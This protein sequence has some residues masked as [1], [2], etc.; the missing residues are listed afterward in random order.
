MAE[1]LTSRDLTGVWDAMDPEDAERF[2]Q[3]ILDPEVRRRWCTAVLVGG[4][5][6]LWQR[7]ASV[8]RKLALDKLELQAGDRVLLF[9]EAVN[10][11]GWDEEIRQRVGSTG[12]VVVIDVRDRVL[13]MMREQ[14]VPWWEWAETSEY[15]DEHFDAVFVGQAVAHAGDWRREG[16][17]ML[18]VMKPGRP[19]VLAEMVITGE[20]FKQ[21]ALADVHVE[22][23]LRKMLE[24]MGLPFD[25]LDY[26]SFRDVV[27]GLTPQLE[28]LE[29]FEWRGVELLWGRKP[30]TRESR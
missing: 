16:A 4:L 15:P 24:G 22:Y 11:I 9:G 29:T 21:R 10:A 18:R 14:Q 5:P 23:W 12:D 19:L 8:P 1:Q 28:E 7:V 20:R 3:D 6:Y 27:D 17:E 26:W 2:G 25:A 13:G 30:G